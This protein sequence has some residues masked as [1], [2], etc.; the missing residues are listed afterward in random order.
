M[1]TTTRSRKGPGGPWNLE[2]ERETTKNGNCQK[3][4]FVQIKQFIQEQF[5]YQKI[6]HK[7]L[8]ESGEHKSEAVRLLLHS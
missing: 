7:K 5:S 8:P 2:N 4:I 6:L 3:I 1:G